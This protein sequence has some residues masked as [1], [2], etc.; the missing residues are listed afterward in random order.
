VAGIGDD[1]VLSAIVNWVTGQSVADLHLQVG[2]LI[3]P[4]NE[5]VVW[6]RQRP[7]KLGD[8]IKVRVVEADSTDKP[9]KRYKRDPAK[10]LR[11]KRAYVRKTAKELR[12]KIEAR[13]RKSPANSRTKK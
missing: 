6:I 2:G 4:G 10:E 1:G 11:A 3:S 9:M 5:R 7:L 13:P 12:W 8:E